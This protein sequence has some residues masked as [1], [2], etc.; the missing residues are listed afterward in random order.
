MYLHR[1]WRKSDSR[2]STLRPFR[3]AFFCISIFCGL[4]VQF[5]FSF[6]AFAIDPLNPKEQAALSYKIM[7]ERDGTESEIN[8]AAKRLSSSAPSAML[9]F[10]QSLALSKEFRD[11]V[12]AK[13]NPRD[14]VSMLY[15]VILNREPEEP[16]LS[17]WQ[18]GISDYPHTIERFF[19]AWETKYRTASQGRFLS[20]Q[21]AKEFFQVEPKFVRGM[22]V[23]LL[24]LDKLSRNFKAV[25]AAFFVLATNCST[26]ERHKAY[27]YIERGLKQWPDDPLLHRCKANLLREDNKEAEAVLEFSKVSRLWPE[28]TISVQTANVARLNKLGRFKEAVMECKAAAA[29][30]WEARMQVAGMADERIK[31]REFD[32]ACALLTAAIDT[33]LG[34]P[35]ILYKRAACYFPMEQFENGV[36]DL[37]AVLKQLPKSAAAFE[38]RAKC[39]QSM[40]KPEL[41]IA[42]FTAAIKISPQANFYARRAEAYARK[43]MFKESESDWAMAIK[44]DPTFQEYYVNR[45]RLL[46]SLSKHKQA[47]PDLNKAIELKPNFLES[48]VLRAQVHRRLHHDELATKDER[49]SRSLAKSWER[50][51]LGDEIPP[52]RD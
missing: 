25:P 50:R 5:A 46:M 20:Q 26:K 2:G 23:E 45:A 28:D 35:D 18:K 14:Q 37:N 47:L 31:K 39:Y 9:Y 38:L 42:D 11:K 15:R 52:H 17:L 7:L 19:D 29:N 24:E 22:N 48:Y 33:G 3:F 43:R 10:W 27:E 6:P 36:A 8:A 21:D 41:A 30:R 4:I 32:N 40:N 16:G 44:L 49:K 34:D 1:R 13:K 12:M 51:T